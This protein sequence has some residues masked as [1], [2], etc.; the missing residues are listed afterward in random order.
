M[1][2]DALEQGG[3]QELAGS[4]LRVLLMELQEEAVPTASSCRRRAAGLAPACVAASDA[5][6]NTPRTSRTTKPPRRQLNTW[7][8][9]RAPRRSGLTATAGRCHRVANGSAL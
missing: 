4:V 9:E 2:P 8:G 7:P 5:R 3:R 1:F 6:L